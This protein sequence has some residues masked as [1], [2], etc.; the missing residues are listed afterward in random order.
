M[1]ETLKNFI[2]LILDKS[3]RWTHKVTI[4]ISIISILFIIDFAFKISY[5]HYLS[6]KLEN[7][8]KIQTLKKDYSNEP[9]KIKKLLKIEN[10]IFYEK[11]YSDYIK[12]NNLS[13]SN[14][15]SEKKQSG[16]IENNDIRDYSWMFVSSSI[17]FIIIIVALTFMIFT[18]AKSFKTILNWF[19]TLIV[20]LILSIVATW[21]AYQIPIILDLP[22]LNYILNF[23]IHCGF[24]YLI[25]KLHK[26]YN[27]D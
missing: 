11:H 18:G 14:P 1:I 20:F 13:I 17:V 2:E 22:V 5:N 9:K 8:E 16:K 12:N 3:K 15:F 6:N 25:I 10:E 26:K 27:V 19:S 24:I 7:L 23:I 4:I 21:F